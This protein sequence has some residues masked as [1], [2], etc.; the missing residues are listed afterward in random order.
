MVLRAQIHPHTLTP[1]HKHVGQRSK[2][3]YINFRLVAA[4]AVVLV[5]VCFCNF[6]KWVFAETVTV[7]HT[8]TR[9]H[10]HA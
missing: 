8:H 7:A 5:V 2:V 1:T 6:S 4:F 10:T 9:A 3:D